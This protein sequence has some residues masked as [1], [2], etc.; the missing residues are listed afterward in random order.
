[1]KYLIFAMFL[2]VACSPE[3]KKSSKPNI[4]LIITD[5]QSWEHLGCYGDPVIRTPVIDKLASEGVKFENAYTACPS[6]SPARA[7]LLTGQDIYRLEEG[8][9]LT[10]FIRDK[11]EVFPLLL[12]EN[13]YHVGYTGKGYWPLTSGIP[14]AIDEPFGKP[15]KSI[16]HDSVPHGVSR[17]YYAANFEQFVEENSGG[18]PFFFL[19]GLGEPHRP[20]GY[21]LGLE[22]GIDTSRVSIPSF[23]PDVSV[24]KVDMAD[25]LGE[26][27]YCDQVVGELL[28]VL[29]KKGLIE[30]TL[31]IFTSDNGMPFPRSKATLY[32]HGV[33]MPLIAWWEN[34]IYGNRVVSDPVSLIDL[35]PTFLELALVDIPEQFTGRSMTTQLL[36]MESGQIEADR[37]FVV[38]AFEKHTHCR[39]NELGYPRRAIHTTEWTYIVN[40]EPHRFPMGNLDIYIPNWDNLGETD[41]GPT[42]TYFKQNIDNPDFQN[43]WNLSFGKVPEE[44]LYNKE[45][46]PHMISN[47][48]NDPASSLIL[49]ELRKKL[50]HYLSL[51]DDPRLRGLSPWDQYRLDK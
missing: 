25:Y 22:M 42:K 10:G 8:G 24:T 3:D 17:N 32:D 37:D 48:A 15:Y 51:T 36:A 38:T 46:D 16:L 43:L 14:E 41:P 6:C 11:F 26:I 21:G 29:D 4:L 50:N 9:V 34:K 19:A 31:I 18:K 2:L 45:E 28:D 12:E 49:D 47:L 44:E 1:M 35:G 23:L 5:D 20:Y 27:E 40:H 13:G 7:A 30:N 33:R 39:P